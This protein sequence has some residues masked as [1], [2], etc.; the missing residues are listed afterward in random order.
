MRSLFLLLVLASGV[1]AQRTVTVV[2]RDYAFQ[3]P[4][5]L[6]AG[7]TTFR[8]HNEG[9]EPH[10]MVLVKLG[11]TDSLGALL[12]PHAPDQFDRGLVGGPAADFPG[13]DQSN[14]TVVL[15]A[16]R[17]AVVCGVP[18]VDHVPHLKK[19]MIRLLIVTPSTSTAA[20]PTSDLTITLVD[21]AFQLSRPIAAGRHMLRIV[22]PS[23]QAHMM[24]L[25]K[26]KP[27]QT[28]DSLLVWGRERKGPAPIEWSTGVSALRANGTAYVSADF[29]PGRYA[30]L[31]FLDAPDGK[32]HFVHGMRQEITV[33]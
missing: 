9:R 29:T 31:C 24:M 21:Y 2:T 8:I 16:G 22:N 18:S 19:G 20:A 15:D 30:L 6:P 10:E 28:T 32:E 5:T 7:L 26:F 25:I 1:H 13:T 14:A 17:Y 33:P 4:D 3:M 27:H 11:A 23:S 12:A